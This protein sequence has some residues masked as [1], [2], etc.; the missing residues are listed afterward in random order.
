MNMQRML[1]RTKILVIFILPAL[2]VLLLRFGLGKAQ[3]DFALTITRCM[4]HT[5]SP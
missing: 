1:V 2:A 3:H 4:A 5:P